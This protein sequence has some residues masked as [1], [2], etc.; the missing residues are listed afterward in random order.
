[1]ERCRALGGT[2]TAKWEVEFTDEFDECYDTYVS[3]A[4]DLYD[5][6]LDELRKEELIK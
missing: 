1:M 4:D 5:E 2:S 6:Y 3:R